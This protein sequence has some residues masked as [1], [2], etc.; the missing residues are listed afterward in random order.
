MARKVPFISTPASKRKRSFRKYNRKYR[1]GR[2]RTYK[3]QTALVKSGKLHPF[4]LGQINPFH[5]NV[6]GVKIPD[7]NSI[8]SESFYQIDNVAFT[9]DAVNG[10][11]SAAFFPGANT[12]MASGGA[13][14]PD[15]WTFG[16][17]YGGINARSDQADIVSHYNTVRS[18]AHGLKLSCP[19]SVTVATGYVHVCLYAMSTF[20]QATWEL[21][22]SVSQM[23]KLPGYKRITLSEL[24][25]RPFIVVNKFVDETAFKYTDVDS[26]EFSSANKH[27]FHIPRGWC[28]VLIAVTGA[29]VSQKCL[30]VVD[31]LH[32][33]GLRRLTSTNSNHQDSAEPSNPEALRTASILG[34]SGSNVSQEPQSDAEQES[35]VFSALN[36]AMNFVRNSRAASDLASAAA[37][38]AV[39]HIGRRVTRGLARGFNPPNHPMYELGYH[40]YP[41]LQNLT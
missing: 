15:S 6:F 38:A 26:D 31:I 30:E 29:G 39:N 20:N 33:E 11:T 18:V 1:Q 8:P 16:A 24:T 40:G 12:F 4:A 36:T 21:P 32:S 13:A 5:D 7:L 23:M 10:V 37:N 34:S 35:M 25:Q 9:T 41:Q 22:V 28:G 3:R 2:K 27:E 17:A 14:G 19:L